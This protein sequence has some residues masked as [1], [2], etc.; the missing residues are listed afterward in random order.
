MLQEGEGNEWQTLEGHMMAIGYIVSKSGDVSSAHFAELITLLA[1]GTTHTYPYGNYV[2]LHALKGDRYYSFV[3]A[4]IQKHTHG[5][6]FSTEKPF[7]P[8]RR[9]YSFYAF[10]AD[11]VLHLI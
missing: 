10:Y 1:G 2:R 6:K 9:Y 5:K 11:K 7:V 8:V 4:L 3:P